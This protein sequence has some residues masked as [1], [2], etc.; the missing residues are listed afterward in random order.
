MSNLTA[1]WGSSATD[2]WFAGDGGTMLHW[3]GVALGPIATGNAANL[4]GLWGS[5]ADDVWAV[6]DHVTL[7]FNGEGWTAAA[8][9]EALTDVWG[10]GPT[11]VY[12]STANGDVLHR[13]GF[14]WQAEETGYTSGA[15]QGIHGCGPGDIWAVGPGGTVLRKAQ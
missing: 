3:D 12:A 10:A 7:H 11:D 15:I 2:I 9:P 5:S 8:N 14:V 6:G 4:T 1:V 13:T